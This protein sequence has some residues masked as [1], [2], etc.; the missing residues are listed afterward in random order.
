MEASFSKKKLL[1]E[2]FPSPRKAKVQH[3][4]V[5]VMRRQQTEDSTKRNK[6]SRRRRLF[7]ARV[8]NDAG[9]AIARDALGFKYSHLKLFNRK[10][11]TEESL[12]D[13][14]EV[15]LNR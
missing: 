11:A 13:D 6:K 7:C 12:C 3:D 8:A 15:L 1:K 9:K 10:L 2:Y 5:N 4:I 14:D